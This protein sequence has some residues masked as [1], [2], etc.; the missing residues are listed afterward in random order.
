MSKITSFF[1]KIIKTIGSIFTG[2]SNAVIAAIEAGL[3]AAKPFFDDALTISEWAAALTP[4]TIDDVVV[5]FAQKYEVDVSTI[6]VSGRR[7]GDI[8]RDLIRLVLQKLFP[9][10]ADRWLNRAIELAYSKIKP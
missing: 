2:T 10:A 8:I 9:G 7:Q 6:V 1:S 3:V 4:T 5:A